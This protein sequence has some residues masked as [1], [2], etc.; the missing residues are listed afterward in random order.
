MDLLWGNYGGT[1]VMYFGKTC[2]KEVADLL[3]TC[4]GLVVY[5]AD[6]LWTC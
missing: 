4:Y 6:L 5:V 1:G 2:Y 3:H